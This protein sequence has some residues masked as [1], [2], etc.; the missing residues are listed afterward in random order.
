MWCGPTTRFSHFMSLST[1]LGQLMGGLL[2]ILFVVLNLVSARNRSINQSTNQPINQSINQSINLSINQSTNQ[3]TNQSINQS[4]NPSVC[5]SAYLSNDLSLLLM[6]F[7]SSCSQKAGINW[8]NP[9]IQTDNKVAITTDPTS[10]IS[11]LSPRR[12]PEPPKASGKN[13]EVAESLHKTWHWIILSNMCIYL[14]IYVDIG[15]HVCWTYIVYS[16][17]INT[18]QTCDVIWYVTSIECEID[19][20]CKTCDTLILDIC[21]QKLNCTV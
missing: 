3:S 9:T 21:Y 2:S 6:W 17:H 13:R 7:S 10:V 11:V 14:C 18:Y 19:A 8:K 15:A 1:S 20:W 4:I 5:L 12:L 16:I